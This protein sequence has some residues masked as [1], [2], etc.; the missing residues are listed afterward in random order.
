MRGLEPIPKKVKG[1]VIPFLFYFIP[2]PPSPFPLHPSCSITHLMGFIVPF[3]V[4]ER[5]SSN[6]QKVPKTLSLK[7]AILG[8][9]SGK[10]GK[11][12]KNVSDN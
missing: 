2:P 9:K 6:G 10:K 5:E 12:V 11:K 8:I 3:S 7:G 1:I 4:V